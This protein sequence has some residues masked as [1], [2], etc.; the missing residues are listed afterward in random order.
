MVPELVLG[1]PPT[2]PLSGTSGDHAGGQAQADAVSSIGQA[3]VIHMHN[4]LQQ[5]GNGGGASMA[6]LCLLV[7]RTLHSTARTEIATLE[8]RR[9]IADLSEVVKDLA[10]R[11]RGPS[12][13]DLIRVLNARP[14][15]RRA[16]KLPITCWAEF[17]EATEAV[18]A[19]EEMLRSGSPSPPAPPVADPA[20]SSSPKRKAPEQPAAPFTLDD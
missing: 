4:L 17:V 13:H 3:R 2:P 19:A 14:E 6:D 16:I 12:V 8:I 11:L 18:L 7:Q 20:P 1:A 9:Q 10:L 5:H 15:A